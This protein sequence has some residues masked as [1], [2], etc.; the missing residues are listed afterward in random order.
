MQL[1]K[2]SEWNLACCY[3][4]CLLRS[5]KFEHIAMQFLGCSGWLPGCFYVATKKERQLSSIS[6]ASFGITF[7]LTFFKILQNPNLK[8]TKP[9]PNTGPPINSV[10]TRTVTTTFEGEFMCEPIR[11]DAP[12]TVNKAFNLG[13]LEGSIAP[14][15]CPG[16]AACGRAV[17]P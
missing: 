16:V 13:A 11:F 12:P 3:C 2:C 7:S 5:S 8:S 10:Q 15:L 4:M 17:R 14:M 9:Q 1:L 6:L